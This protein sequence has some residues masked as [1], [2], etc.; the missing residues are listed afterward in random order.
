MLHFG[1]GGVGNA[2]HS[3]SSMKEV[4]RCAL[5]PV[6]GIWNRPG[7][8]STDRHC[9]SDIE[10]SDSTIRYLDIIFIA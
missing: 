5:R 2:G 4:L 3:V 1:E 10:A 9:F 8:I 7:F 6:D